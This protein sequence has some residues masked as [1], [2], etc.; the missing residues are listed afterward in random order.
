MLSYKEKPLCPK[1]SI[2]DDS[3]INAPLGSVGFIPEQGFDLKAH[4]VSLERH[5]I[6]QALKESDGIVSRAADF[7]KKCAEQP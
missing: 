2:V 6:D 4:L 5:L 1:P 7:F 3:Q